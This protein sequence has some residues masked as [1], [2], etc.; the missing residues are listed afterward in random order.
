MKKLILILALAGTAAAQGP[1]YPTYVRKPK[2]AS[3]P[4]PVSPR[5][6]LPTG[7]TYQQGTETYKVTGKGQSVNVTD[8]LPRTN[9]RPPSPYTNTGPRVFSGGT[10]LKTT[11]LGSEG[12]YPGQ[13]P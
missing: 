8:R 5:D 4:A 3:S 9:G 7:A 11:K 6:V 13:I 2:P 12:N 10:P 1:G